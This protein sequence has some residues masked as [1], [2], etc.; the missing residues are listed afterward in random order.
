MFLSLLKTFIKDL[1]EWKDVLHIWCLVEKLINHIVLKWT[2]KFN[3]KQVKQKLLEVCI[4]WKIV[5]FFE[6]YI[7]PSYKNKHAL[8]DPV[9]HQL[10]YL[11]LYN[12]IFSKKVFH[13]ELLDLVFPYT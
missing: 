10:F 5:G 12:F 4:T 6:F 11:L 8:I 9:Y 13:W 7:F 1:F 3:V 2:I